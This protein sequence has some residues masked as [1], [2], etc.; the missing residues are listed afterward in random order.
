MHSAVLLLLCALAAFRWVEA[1]LGIYWGRRVEDGEFPWLVSLANINPSSSIAREH[2]C[3]GSL[4]SEWHVRA[5]CSLRI[6]GFAHV[7]GPVVCVCRFVM[8]AAHCVVDKDLSRINGCLNDTNRLCEKGIVL[9]F[10]FAYVVSLL[11]SS[12]TV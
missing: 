5:A 9:N 6:S 1:N 10:D 4:V 11:R 8:T 12:C 7:G 3:G 2:Y